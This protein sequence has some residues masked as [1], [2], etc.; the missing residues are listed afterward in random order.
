MSCDAGGI[1][2]NTG[3]IGRLKKEKQAGKWKYNN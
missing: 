2:I 1:L 3:E